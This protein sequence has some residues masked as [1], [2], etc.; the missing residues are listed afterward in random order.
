MTLRELCEPLF[1]YICRL[2]RT[3]RK[4]GEAEIS[5]VRSEI[6]GLF[7]DMKSKAEADAG[8]SEQYA[9]TERALVFFTDFMVSNS[10]MPSVAEAWA[11]EPFAL[12]KG[13]GLG[14]DEKFFDELDEALADSSEAA[15]ERLG[16]F[17][18][19]MGLGFTGFYIGQPE[20]LRKRM[21]QCSERT[22]R[23]MD[24]EEVSR[25]CPEAYDNADT[26]DLVEPPGKKLVG[27]A[28]VLIG[29][30]IIVFVANTLLFEIKADELKTSL[31]AINKHEPTV[32]APAGAGARPDGS[33]PGKDK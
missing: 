27:I 1:L 28:I 12:E 14:G 13:F 19:C 20:H 23:M 11:Q 31:K 9:K 18:V 22:R 17:Y 16:I 8:L 7:D 29:L 4:G 2:N 32:S 24:I 5:R 3:G 26:R 33:S 25:I 10:G 21:L 6:R 30:I 15:S